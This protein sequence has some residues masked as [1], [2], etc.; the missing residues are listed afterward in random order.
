MKRK[1]EK[2]YLSYFNSRIFNELLMPDNKLK[3]KSIDNKV[4]IIFK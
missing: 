4:R 2:E 1:S 3:N